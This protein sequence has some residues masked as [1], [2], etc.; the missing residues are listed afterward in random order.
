LG[1]CAPASVP[2]CNDAQSGANSGKRREPVVPMPPR[3]PAANPEEAASRNV[4]KT[5]SSHSFIYDLVVELDGLST[6]Q[7]TSPKNF[8][9]ALIVFAGRSRL[10]SRGEEGNGDAKINPLFEAGSGSFVDLLNETNGKSGNTE[11]G[12]R[13]ED[14]A[15]PL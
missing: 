9:N 15:G 7:E 14:H 10:R 6:T 11:N 8:W 3:P 12:N 2:P 5:L 1:E 4:L 13:L